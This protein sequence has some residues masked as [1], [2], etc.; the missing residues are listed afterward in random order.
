MQ[1]GE[2]SERGSSGPW[3]PEDRVG[4]AVLDHRGNDMRIRMDRD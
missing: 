4:V 2:R 1:F 3:L